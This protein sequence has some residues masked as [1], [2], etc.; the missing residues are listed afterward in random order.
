MTDTQPKDVVTPEVIPP[1]PG[2][3]TEG[4]FDPAV[5]VLSVKDR[6]RQASGKTTRGP[7]RPRTTPPPGP[8]PEEKTLEQIR[9]EQ[10]TKRTRADEIAETITGDINDMFL[11]AIISQGL[12]PAVIYMKGYIPPATKAEEKYTTFGQRLAI[13]SFTAS[14]VGS[15]LAELESNESTAKFLGSATGGTFGMVL[16]GT[17]AGVCVIGWANGV[18][19]AFDEMGKLRQAWEEA[20]KQQAQSRNSQGDENDY[21]RLT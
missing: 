9:K 2:A 11:K 1:D 17:L 8:K 18:R 13:D 10:K 6:I 19:K 16:K 15:F 3:F 7:G 4:T 12:P 14:M 21:Y 20:K 5:N